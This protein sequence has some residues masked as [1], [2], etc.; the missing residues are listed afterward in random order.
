[1]PT[2]DF[3]PRPTNIDV[4]PMISALQFQPTDFEFS[5][6]WLRH[7]PSHHLFKFDKSGRVTIE[8]R[9]ECSRRPVRKDQGDQLFQAF[10]AWR[11]YYW[12]P[13]QVDREFA[14]HFRKPD[15]WVRLF[16]DIRMAWRRFVD[17][18]EPTTLPAE[19]LA[20]VMVEQR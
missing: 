13:L 3:S 2:I 16:R 17:K 12:E 19:A 5:N 14:G 11:Q 1:M 15:A 4:S 8:A 20:M 9:C 10:K 7:V 18:A 6:G